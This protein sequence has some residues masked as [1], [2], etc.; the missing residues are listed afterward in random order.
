VGLAIVR[1]DACNTA[2]MAQLSQ[3]YPIVLGIAGYR[4]EGAVKIE[5]DV[6]NHEKEHDL[7]EHCCA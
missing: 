1:R 6:S 7:C 4:E 3:F 5:P 2:V